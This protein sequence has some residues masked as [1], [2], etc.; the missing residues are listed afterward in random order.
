MVLTQRG[1]SMQGGE[2]EARAEPCEVR[3]TG[4]AGPHSEV[5]H[6]LRQPVLSPGGLWTSVPLYKEGVA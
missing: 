6:G 5:L 1:R 2:Q 4:R 3:R